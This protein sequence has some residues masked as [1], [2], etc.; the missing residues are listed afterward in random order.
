MRPSATR[1][2]HAIVSPLRRTA[3][4]PQNGERSPRPRA[5]SALLTPSIFRPATL[6]ED[7]L[8]LWTAGL[9][10]FHEFC[11]SNHV[12]E[13]SRMPASDF[14]LSSFV[15]H[16][17]GKVGKS[18]VDNWIAGLQLWHN[19]HDAPWRGSRALA[20]ASRGVAKSTPASSRRPK[21]A[22]VTIDH[23]RA[24]RQRLDL[25]NAFDSAVYA[26]AAIAFRACCR[27][28]EL[29]LPSASGFDATRHV[30]NDVTI[31]FKSTADGS[32]F[33]QFHIPF[34]KTTGIQGADIFLMKASDDVCAMEALRHHKAVNKAVPRDAPLFAWTTAD[35]SW[36]P[37]TKDWFLER[38]GEVWRACGLEVVPGHSFRIGGTT[39]LLLRGVEPG[40]VAMQGRWTSA[41]FLK[42]WRQVELIL[43]RFL[44]RAAPSV[45]L[46]SIAAS[47]TRFEAQLV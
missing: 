13:S 4:Q 45:S 1:G 7:R 26:V 6:A 20:A 38:C 43:P 47:V 33:A 5:P 42:Y 3:A 31:H 15:A 35:G 2:P 34:S 29:V 12:A 44:S 22:P 25:S 36:A 37:M 28:G 21:R 10:R 27:L 23:A 11:D 24:L 8:E 30:A 18:A 41:A 17:L 40:I 39:D 14:L 9:L 32:Q 46:E 16:H 19:I